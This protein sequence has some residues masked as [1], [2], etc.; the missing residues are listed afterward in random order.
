MSKHETI[1]NYDIAK[2]GLFFHLAGLSRFVIKL[3]KDSGQESFMLPIAE[4]LDR[5]LM[6]I[7]LGK[8]EIPGYA[9]SLTNRAKIIAYLRTEIEASMETRR[10]NPPM[11][12]LA[13][14][15]KLYEDDFKPMIAFLGTN[16]IYQFI[17]EFVKRANDNDDLC[18]ILTESTMMLDNVINRHKLLYTETK[19]VERYKT[20]FGELLDNCY[21][22][23]SHDMNH[24]DTVCSTALKLNRK[25]NLKL[26][27]REI[28]VASLFHDMFDSK[29]RENHHLLASKW[30]MSSMHPA[31]NL[32]DKEKQLRVANAIKEH[33]ASYT[34]EYSSPLSELIATADREPPNLEA[35]IRRAYKYQLDKHKD[36][37][38]NDKLKDVIKHLIEKF[39][40]T[41]YSKYTYMYLLEYKPELDI[42]HDL[43]KKIEKG[44]IKV[45]I[46]VIG[47]DIKV[48]LKRK[49]R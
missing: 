5:I 21:S 42:M 36:K 39:G 4:E 13:I 32:N 41:G 31:I 11:L 26:D 34:G 24:I 7:F 23:L 30:V 44:T 28:I 17:E 9:L 27:I 14:I 48:N 2:W 29:D 15:H 18:S 8:K 43:I 20:E 16:V 25:Y 3:S 37:P 6:D 47:K 46:A 1:L 45:N 38:H 10:R 40:E 19:M 35:I 49:G 12:M 33:R 22:S